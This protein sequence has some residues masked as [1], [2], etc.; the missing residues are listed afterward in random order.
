MEEVDILRQLL[1]GEAGEGATGIE[2][3]EIPGLEIADEDSMRHFARL[4]RKSIAA[5]LFIGF[6]A[7]LAAGL[8]FNED[9]P[10][11]EEV[12]VAVAPIH[13]LD[14]FLEN[15]HTAAVDAQHI[16]KIGLE[17]LGLRLLAYGILV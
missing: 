5:G 7:V 6:G 10:G 1:Q 8:H 11:P 17:R 16:Q 12:D 15:G 13:A 2:V 4:K 9:M 3:I 14:L